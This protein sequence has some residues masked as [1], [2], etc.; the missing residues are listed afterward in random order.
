MSMSKRIFY[1]TRPVSVSTSN[2][3]LFIV[4]YG[5]NTP[6]IGELL[7]RKSTKISK[8]IPKNH[9]K[10]HWNVIQSSLGHAPHLLKWTNRCVFFP[11]YRWSVQ[12]CQLYPNINDLSP[13]FRHESHKTIIVCWDMSIYADVYCTEVILISTASFVMEQ[14]GGL[15]LMT[16]F[17]AAWSW[18]L[19]SHLLA[20]HTL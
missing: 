5:I 10:L 15:F 11:S 7:L 9:S 3:D 1:S 2:L 20:S 13:R 8:Y 17:L 4:H 6:E 18:W 14:L 19:S 16:V 12:T